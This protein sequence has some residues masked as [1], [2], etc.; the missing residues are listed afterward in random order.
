MTDVQLPAVPLTGP[1]PAELPPVDQFIHTR[2][3]DPSWQSRLWAIAPPTEHKA[4]FVIWWEPG[5]AWEPVQR[6]II[7]QV[8]P[9]STI[10]D[11]KEIELV[12]EK[13]RDQLQGPHPRSGGEYSPVAQRWI[14][15]PAPLITKTAWE[16]HRVHRG[17]AKPYWV[18][19]GDQGGHRYRLHSWESYLS[20]LV[21]GK[22]DTPAPGDLPYAE[23]D[24]R[25][26]RALAEAT[27]WHEL[28]IKS[29]LIAKSHRSRLSPVEWAEIET[30][31]RAV[32]KHL[33]TQAEEHSDELGWA[34]RKAQL[35]TPVG[36][37][38][39]KTDYDQADHEFVEDLAHT[40]AGEVPS[41]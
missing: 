7:Y 26:F 34:L 13:V 19:Q 17:W 28:A 8:L 41:L 36:F 35:S 18:I 38:P 37:R 40:I 32:S 31:A 11:K 33:G 16:I 14:K 15:G 9:Y 21:G 24:E 10:R 2:E 39:Q 22:T 3:P 6:W 20:K 5:D 23:P 30:A 4:K 27:Q 1:T 25:T 29:A 12:P